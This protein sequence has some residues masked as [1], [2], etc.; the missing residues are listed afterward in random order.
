MQVWLEE[1]GVP[2]PLLLDSERKVYRAYG[3]GRS[4]LQVWKPRVL[5][6]YL[7]L[8]LAGR[9]LK[10]AQGDIYQLGGDFI[11]DE[12]G[13]VRLIHPSKDPTDRPSVDS[14]LTAAREMLVGKGDLA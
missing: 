6:H 2:F 1:T 13:T 9:R 12:Q 10:P 4:V 7:R 11:V 14:L 3:L 5:V 8:V